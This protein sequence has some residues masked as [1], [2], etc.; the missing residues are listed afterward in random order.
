ME[1]HVC[2]LDE[3][4]SYIG[5]LK[6]THVLTVIEKDHK[7]DLSMAWCVL[8][9]KVVN[10]HDVWHKDADGCPT[11]EDCREIIDWGRTLPEDAVVLVHCY[12]GISRSTCATLALMYDNHRIML[13]E[14][15][16]RLVQNRKIAFPNT[17][18]AE[19]FD[20]LFDLNGEFI[21]TVHEIRSKSPFLI[22]TLNDSVN[23]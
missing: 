11:I 10:F 7:I 14:A 2:A 8:E 22:H 4:I 17:L 23:E 5:K 21:R 20:A 16:A 15:A 3:L 1:F 12:A 19:H 18:M 9:H 6:P 13:E